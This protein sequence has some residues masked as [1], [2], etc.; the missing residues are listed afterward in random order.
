MLKLGLKIITV[1]LIQAL[2]LTQVD[3]AVAA[4][5][6]ARNS[7]REAALTYH[8]MSAKAANPVNGAGCVRAALSGIN[9]PGITIKNLLAFLGG[10][11][12][13]IIGKIKGAGNLRLVNNEFYKVFAVMD[14]GILY[15][16]TILGFAGEKKVLRA[17]ELLNNILNTRAPPMLTA[18]IFSTLTEP[19]CLF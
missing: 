10:Q 5:N 11:D 16:N 3:F 12:T 6:D 17:R 15:N 19:N 7:F 9:L 18:K 13:S 8:V 2:L 1:L 4:M 14:A